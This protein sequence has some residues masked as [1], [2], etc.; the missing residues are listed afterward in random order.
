M[1]LRIRPA[2]AGNAGALAR[3]ERKARTAFAIYAQED[4]K[5]VPAGEGA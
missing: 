1:L 3:T 2:S 4:V 5:H